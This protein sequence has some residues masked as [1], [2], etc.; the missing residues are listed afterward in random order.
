MIMACIF[1]QNR[2]DDTG[3]GAG[4]IVSVQLTPIIAVSSSSS[5]SSN[6]LLIV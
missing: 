4:T 3:N 2:K 6:I 1:S 5:S